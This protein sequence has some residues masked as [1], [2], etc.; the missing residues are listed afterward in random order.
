MSERQFKVNIVQSLLFRQLFV[1]ALFLID[2]EYERAVA[3]VSLQNLKICIFQMERQKQI[4]HKNLRFNLYKLGFTSIMNCICSLVGVQVTYFISPRV[5]LM[6]RY[7]FILYNFWKEN[8][9]QVQFDTMLQQQS[10]LS[11]GLLSLVPL[12]VLKYLII[13]VSVLALIGLLYL[14]H[15]K[16]VLCL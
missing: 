16:Q 12:F 4:A 14:V 11:C 8:M 3:V 6:I 1:H 9:L 15:D 13:L 7:V 2:L 10:C 5:A